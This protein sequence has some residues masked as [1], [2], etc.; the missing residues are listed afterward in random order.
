MNRTFPIMRTIDFICGAKCDTIL[1]QM[2]VCV[3]RVRM[4]IYFYFGAHIVPLLIYVSIEKAKKRLAS[5]LLLHP[6]IC[7]LL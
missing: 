2:C 4:F 1:M 6:S 5:L 3:V 7:N